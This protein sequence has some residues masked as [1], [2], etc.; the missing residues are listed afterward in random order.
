MIG[1]RQ[2][3]HQIT[4][5]W[6]V[7]HVT[8]AKS[9]VAIKPDD[10]F[11]WTNLGGELANLEMRVFPT[12]LSFLFPFSSFKDIFFLPPLLVLT[13]TWKWDRNEEVI[14]FRYFL[15]FSYIILSAR[16]SKKLLW[17]E[18]NKHWPIY[19]TFLLNV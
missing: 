5:W 3:F 12:V 13:C 4:K 8:I 17:W 10:H 19:F 14:F 15:T 9:M 2:S 18:G 6:V 16:P 1:G 7:C 11:Q